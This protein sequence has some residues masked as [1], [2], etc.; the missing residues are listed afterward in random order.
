MSRIN[1]NKYKTREIRSLL[2]AEAQLTGHSFSEG[3]PSSQA[4][5]L[6]PFCPAVHWWQLSCCIYI[7]NHS[8]LLHHVRNSISQAV[9][10]YLSTQH[11][12]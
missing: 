9:F 8:L 7:T 2:C 11:S 1:E 3:F 10:F 6:P 5:F 12:S 4:L